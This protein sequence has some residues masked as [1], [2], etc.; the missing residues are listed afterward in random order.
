VLKNTSTSGGALATKVLRN[1]DVER[2]LGRRNARSARSV[3][4]PRDQRGADDSVGSGVNDRD[5]GSTLVRS[6]NFKLDRDLLAGSKGLD[7]IL[8]VLVLETLALP[9]LALLSVVIGLGSGNL[10]LSLD[11]SIVITSYFAL[12]SPP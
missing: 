3:D 10:E 7:K 6:A 1:G 12:V 11:V 8:V 4:V 5:V 9:D 2:G